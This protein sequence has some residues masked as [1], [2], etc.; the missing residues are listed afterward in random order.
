MARAPT[1]LDRQFARF[2][3]EKMKETGWSYMQ[4]AKKTGTSDATIHRLIHLER[5]AT[6]A[7]MHQ[8]LRGLG[9]KPGDVFR[10]T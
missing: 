9:A 8:I 10:D 4:M 6:L 7:M 5:S 1:P 3:T 2:L